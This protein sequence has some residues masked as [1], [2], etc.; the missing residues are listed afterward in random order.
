MKILASINFINRTLRAVYLS[1]PAEH[2]VLGNDLLMKCRQELKLGKY[3]EAY[4]IAQNLYQLSGKPKEEVTSLFHGVLFAEDVLTDNSTILINQKS[5]YY[6]S[7]CKLSEE[8]DFSITT[9]QFPQGNWTKDYVISVGDEILTSAVKVKPYLT[10]SFIS[11][12]KNNDKLYYGKLNLDQHH[13]SKTNIKSYFDWWN[14]SKEVIGQ[15]TLL[16]KV[17]IE[18][19]NLFCAINKFGER[20]YL[21]GENVV[22]ETMA[23]NDCSRSIAIELILAELPCGPKNLLIIP[24]WTYHLDLQMAYLGNG[25]FIVH[26]FQQN[27]IDFELSADIIA[28]IKD[29]FTSLEK[30][31]EKSII[32]QTCTLLEKHGFEVAKVFGCL[33]YLDNHEDP[34]ELAFVPY[35]KSSDC[36][37]GALALMMNGVALDLN[38]GRYFIASHCEMKSFVSQFEASLQKLGIKELRS[39]DMLE[40]Y[41][42]DGSFSGIYYGIMGATSVTQ[43]V[44]TM[45]GALRCQTSVISRS[46]LR[47]HSFEQEERI[48][49]RFFQV[50]KVKIDDEKEKKAFSTESNGKDTLDGPTYI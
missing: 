25:Q 44:A 6:K 50:P 14:S 49:S 45:N 33:F 19:G 48:S 10:P 30:K 4:K 29:T 2:K 34:A 3:K 27:D 31:F 17:V 8:L 42:Y 13:Q 32:D 11:T 23:Y 16:H 37:D 18:G 28:K 21:V 46:I 47:I 36:Y 15:T 22:S 7:L 40:G 5:P 41:D 24:Q 1:L 26:S 35:C 38:S 20:F 43:V 39:V 12:A 9:H